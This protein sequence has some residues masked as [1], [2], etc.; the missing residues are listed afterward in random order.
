MLIRSDL[1]ESLRTVDKMAGASDIVIK[2]VEVPNGSGAVAILHTNG[3]EREE[4]AGEKTRRKYPSSRDASSASDGF[5]S[6]LDLD[7]S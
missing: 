7:P 3:D 4:D 5:P 6:S 1:E 2:E